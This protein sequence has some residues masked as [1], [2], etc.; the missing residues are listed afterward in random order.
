M[1]RWNPFVD[2][3]LH[4][5][6]L[7][8][9]SKPVPSVTLTDLTAA[10]GCHAAFFLSLTPLL[11]P[12][13]NVT[14]PPYISH[15]DIFLSMTF[16]FWYFIYLS[17]SGRRGHCINLQHSWDALHWPL[18]VESRHAKGVSLCPHMSSCPH[19]HTSRRTV[20]FTKECRRTVFQ[21][22]LIFDKRHFLTFGSKYTFSMDPTLRFLNEA[23]GIWKRNLRLSRSAAHIRIQCDFHVTLDQP[24]NTKKKP[25]KTLRL[26][27]ACVTLKRWL[28]W[29]KFHPSMS[30]S[31]N[32]RLQLCIH[33]LLCTAVVVFSPQRAIVAHTRSPSLHSSP[34]HHLLCQPPL[35]NN[36]NVKVCALPFVALMS[37]FTFVQ[38][39]L[40][41]CAL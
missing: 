7:L 29:N 3:F 5:G 33:T 12:P 2:L 23:P 9:I 16:F 14:S 35:H 17:P 18:T 25:Q 19:A 32:S 15:T 13:N 27:V 30:P 38:R 26:K 11:S 31:H 21:I 41:V 37:L 34:S 39:L 10:T 22:W 36:L 24:H 1:V 40:C 6:P 20:W 8:F 28:E 4:I